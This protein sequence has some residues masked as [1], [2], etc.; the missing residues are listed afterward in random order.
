MQQHPKLQNTHTHNL[1]QSGIDDSCSTVL[2][3][4][5]G[6]HW[7][8]GSMII[9]SFTCTCRFQIFFFFDD[10]QGIVRVDVGFGGGLRT[11]CCMTTNSMTVWIYL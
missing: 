10:T 2:M 9:M 1:C 5:A 3:I 7:M 4:N 6:T 8:S 11:V